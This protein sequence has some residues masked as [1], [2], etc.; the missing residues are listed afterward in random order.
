[1]LLVL[2]WQMVFVNEWDEEDC[3][4]MEALLVAARRWRSSPFCL[5]RGRGC[6][7]WFWG[8]LDAFGLIGKCVGRICEI[9]KAIAAGVGFRAD[10][11]SRQLCVGGASRCRSCRGLGFLRTEKR[12]N[13]LRCVFL[14]GEFECCFIAVCCGQIRN[15]CLR[16]A[17]AGL[18]SKRMRGKGSTRLL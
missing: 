11:F 6:R 1:M 5:R 12:G 10:D 17:W 9:S 2:A 14:Y 4:R 16:T 8:L 18:R 7:G 15:G 3:G 13:G